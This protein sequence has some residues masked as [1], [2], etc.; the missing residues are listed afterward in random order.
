MKGADF[1]A[2]KTTEFLSLD[3]RSPKVCAKDILY[4]V[5]KCLASSPTLMGHKIRAR[6]VRELELSKAEIV[7]RALDTVLLKGVTQKRAAPY[8]VVVDVGTR[9]G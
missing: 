6:A 9:A 7:R 4:R 8:C 1:A 3:I 2:L 5:H